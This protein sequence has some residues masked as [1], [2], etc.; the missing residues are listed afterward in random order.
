MKLD[1]IFYDSEGNYMPLN[2]NHGNTDENLSILRNSYMEAEK[3][4][5]EELLSDDEIKETFLKIVENF[6]NPESLFRE[7]MKLQNQIENGMVESQKDFEKM[8]N[9]TE[10]ER[11]EYHIRKLERLEGTMCLL[12]AAAKDKVSI[13][14]LGVK[15]RK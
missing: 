15:I 11:E 8:K 1:G 12:F 4:Y 7:A 13:E 5:F 10:R 14:E 2:S 3:E 9:M 6:D